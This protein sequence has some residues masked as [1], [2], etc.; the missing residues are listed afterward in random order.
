MAGRA[1]GGTEE[2]ALSGSV[3]ELHETSCEPPADDATLTDLDRRCKSDSS[4][5]G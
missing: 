3:N 1:W 4:N 2:A 5:F